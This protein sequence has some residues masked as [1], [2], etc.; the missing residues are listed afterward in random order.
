[1]Y[2]RRN[3]QSDVWFDIS[4]LSFKPVNDVGPLMDYHAADLLARALTV[5]LATSILGGCALAANI[6]FVARIFRVPEF[7][8]LQ[9]MGFVMAAVL[10]LGLA[11]WYT[12]K[13]LREPTP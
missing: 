9:S 4:G 8:E 5:W 6:A 7:A 2:S 11:A 10:G 1:V 12:L 13:S 3:P